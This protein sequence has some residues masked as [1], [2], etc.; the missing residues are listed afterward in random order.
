MADAAFLVLRDAITDI[1]GVVAR[2]PDKSYKRH[3]GSGLDMPSRTL[4]VQGFP[5]SWAFNHWRTVHREGRPE[6]GSRPPHLDQGD[7]VVG[8]TVVVVETA[9]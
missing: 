9:T 6:G 5:D 4:G 2:R 1:M 7:V 3:A 8:G